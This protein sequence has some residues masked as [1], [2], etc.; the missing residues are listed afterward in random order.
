MA[1]VLGI[2]PGTHV[3]GY[4]VLD[5]KDDGSAHAF[6]ECG[7]V[8]L[9][10]DDPLELR[11]LRLREGLLEIV[12]RLSPDAIAIESPFVGR[13]VKAAFSV[14]EAR[15]VALVIAAERGIPVRQYAP[16]QVKSTVAGHGRASKQDVDRLL[17]MQVTMPENKVPADATDALAVAMCDAVQSSSLQTQTANLLR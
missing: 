4:G 17:R 5:T 12:G 6:V 14:G 3:A 9:K 7:V 2:D 16:A 13:N 8:R 15:G 11:L 1:R 10:R